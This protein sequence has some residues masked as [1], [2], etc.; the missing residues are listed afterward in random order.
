M[1]SINCIV[2]INM[3]QKIYVSMKKMIMTLLGW[4]ATCLGLFGIFVFAMYYI[5]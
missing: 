3:N 5:K 4:I 2:V 1:Y